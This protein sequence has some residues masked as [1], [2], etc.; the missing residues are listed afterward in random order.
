MTLFEW[1]PNLSVKNDIM[2]A[3]HKELVRILNELFDAM[4][5]GRG[6]TIMNRILDDLATYTIQHFTREESLMKSSSYPDVEQHME[7][8]YQLVKEVTRFKEDYKNKKRELS[9]EVLSYLKAW[10]TDHIQRS[11]KQFGNYL[12]DRN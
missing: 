4:K 3:D 2:D 1:T 10:L 11:D 9:G 8:H 12:F 5:E 7:E 6:F